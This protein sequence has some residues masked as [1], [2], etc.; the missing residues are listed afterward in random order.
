MEK[1]T[2]RQSDELSARNR[3]SASNPA[4]PKTTA[5]P[6]PKPPAPKPAPAPSSSRHVKP[7]GEGE[8]DESFAKRSSNW[9]MSQERL[10]S[11]GISNGVNNSSPKQLEA[12]KAKYGRTPSGYNPDAK[13]PAPPKGGYDNDTTKKALPSPNRNPIKDSGNVSG[14]SGSKSDSDMGPRTSLPKKITAID[15]KAG[16]AIRSTFKKAKEALGG[17]GSQ[18][19]KEKRLLRRQKAL[20]GGKA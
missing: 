2:P 1:F 17:G 14:S 8:S 18:Y 12:F 7:Q 13:K 9:N 16:P 20:A 5:G 11:V 15:A 19:R 4:V 3:M 10:K 6:G